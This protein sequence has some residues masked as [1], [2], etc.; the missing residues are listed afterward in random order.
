ME[1]AALREYTL[2]DFEYKEIG[3][4]GPVLEVYYHGLRCAVKRLI[5]GSIPDQYGQRGGDM[6]RRF[7][8]ECRLLTQ[9]RH[10]NIVQF[11]GVHFQSGATIP[12]LVMEFLPSTLTQ[13]INKNA[14]LGSLPDEVI[15]SILSDVALGLNYLHGHSLPIIH[16]DLSTNN[17]LLTKDLTAKIS[18]LG[19]AKILNVNPLEMSKL[20]KAPGTLCYMPPEAL[21]DVPE[22]NASIDIFSYGILLIHIFSGRW[23][24]PTQSVIVDPNDSKKL[25]AVSEA[26]RRQK[27]LDDITPNH[28]PMDLILSCINNSPTCCP[29]ATK[30]L[31]VVKDVEAR[32][33]PTGK[34]E[35]LQRV[36]ALSVALET[37]EKRSKEV[38]SIS[39]STSAPKSSRSEHEGHER[40][41]DLSFKRTV[42]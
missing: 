29:T 9:I 40:S 22:Y 26:K 39:C 25:T 5:P 37:V 1:Q 8:D 12:M 7:T 21:K 15:Y 20:T 18:D 28:P 4:L 34:E 13:R 24:F 35:L 16:R 2:K 23:P 3:L 36:K 41:L 42:S 10:P 14:E 32:F 30:I 17:I 27:Y 31:G 33:T 19:V 38:T 11:L 6:I